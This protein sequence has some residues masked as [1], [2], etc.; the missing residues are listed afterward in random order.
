VSLAPLVE[1]W[2]GLTVAGWL[3]R[4]VADS[5]LLYDATSGPGPG[6]AAVPPLPDRPFSEAARTPPGKLRIAVSVKPP[7]GVIT[8]V[9]GEVRSAVER[10]GE[11]LRSLG[12][13]VHE[14]EP[15]YG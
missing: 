4:Q 15:D 3:T 1:H 10:T 12:H 2:H 13:E 14:R 7:P 8:K 5:A 9:D 11:L 6:D